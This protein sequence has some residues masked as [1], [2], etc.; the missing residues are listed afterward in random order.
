LK[1]TRQHSVYVTG[2]NLFYENK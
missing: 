1:E 2:V